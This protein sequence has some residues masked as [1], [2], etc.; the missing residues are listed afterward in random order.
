MYMFHLVPNYIK[1]ICMQYI[2]I[3][4]STRSLPA[5]QTWEYHEIKI[6]QENITPLNNALTK[7]T[8][9]IPTAQT[10]AI[11]TINRPFYLISIFHQKTIK[12]VLYSIK[13][14]LCL[15]KR[16]PYFIT[17][18][19]VAL[20][21]WLRPFRLQGPRQLE[22]AELQLE[23]ASGCRWCRQST[24]KFQSSVATRWSICPIYTYIYKYINIYK[25]KYVYMYT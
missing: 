5:Q 21:S 10:A 20:R 14:A 17:P 15:I 7:L 12:R 22:K 8:T 11:K 1:N 19:N 16:A 18:P 6:K 25:F 13:R 9:P 24:R 23:R 3:W 2:K 4:K